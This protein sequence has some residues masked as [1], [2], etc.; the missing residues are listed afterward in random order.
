[1]KYS[2]S[3]EDN[4]LVY[5]A[6]KITKVGMKI[7]KQTIL[8]FPD[9]I[10]KNGII[11]DKEHFV[12]LLRTLVK[13]QHLNGKTV[14]VTLPATAVTSRELTLPCSSKSKEMRE[15]VSNEMLYHAEGLTDYTIEYL[16]LDQGEHKDE[17]RVLAYSILNRIMADLLECFTKANLTIQRVEISSNS[18]SKIFSLKEGQDSTVLL[19]QIGRKSIDLLLIETGF[20]VLYQ[21]LRLNLNTFTDSDTLDIM[22]DEIADHINRVTQ[23]NYA[24]HHNKGINQ[25]RLWCDFSEGETLLNLLKKRVNV[26]CS[27]FEFPSMIEISLSEGEFPSDYSAAAG[28]LILRK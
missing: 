6:G 13:E 8:D 20:C 14:S 25:I 11:Q 26:P 17:C 2:V 28:A 22:A 15:M 24:R 19:L 10:I 5:L 1:M 4:R 16:I 23:F 21:N 18:Q 9:S 12:L 7:E 3:V 27:S